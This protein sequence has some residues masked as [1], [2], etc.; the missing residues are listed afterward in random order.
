MKNSYTS[1]CWMLKFFILIT[2]AA[3]SGALAVETGLSEGSL[4]PDF[5]VNNLQGESFHLSDYRGKKPV[6]LVFWG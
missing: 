3:A 2:L 4:A 5:Q 6:Y 1:S